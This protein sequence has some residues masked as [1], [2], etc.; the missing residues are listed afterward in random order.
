MVHLVHPEFMNRDSEKVTDYGPSIVEA[1]GDES[2]EAQ[3]R[4]LMEAGIQDDVKRMVYDFSDDEEIP[5]DVGEFLEVTRSP[6]FDIFE[7]HDLL[8]RMRERRKTLPEGA[9]PRD[10]DIDEEYDD[11][12]KSKK[13]EDPESDP[14]QEPTE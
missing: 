3:I 1:F 9:K 12:G 14:D 8:V 10:E 4:R 7:A 13:E 2:N 6:G 11:S 5:D